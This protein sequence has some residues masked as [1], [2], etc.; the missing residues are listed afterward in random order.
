WHEA[1]EGRFSFPVHAVLALPLEGEQGRLG[2]IG[3]FSKTGERPFSDE[4]VSLVRL[5]SANVSTA[6]RL[7]RANSA[8]E[9]G[10]RLTTIGRLLSPVIH[11]FKTPMTVISG[12]VQLMVDENDRE[13]R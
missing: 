4:D 7:F 8:R 13:K 6:V 9:R 3:L 5:V 2:A 11:D 10:E 1:V 12:C